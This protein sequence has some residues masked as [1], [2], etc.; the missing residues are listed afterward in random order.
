MAAV[1]LALRGGPT[2]DLSFAE[3]CEAETLIESLD[4]TEEN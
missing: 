2:P 3:W 4:A 1:T